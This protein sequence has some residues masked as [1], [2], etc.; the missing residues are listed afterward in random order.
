M[1]GYRFDLSK[2]KSYD[3]GVDKLPITVGQLIYEFNHLLTKL[4]TRSPDRYKELAGVKQINP[5]PVFTPIPGNV[6]EWERV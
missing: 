6:E 4:K 1:R 3:I 2:I 5:H